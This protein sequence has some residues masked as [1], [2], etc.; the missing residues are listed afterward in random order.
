LKNTDL[1]AHFQIYF[2]ITSIFKSLK[3]CTIFD[4]SPLHQFSKFNNFLWVCWFLGK[5][6][7]NFV[8]PAWKLFIYDFKME[9]K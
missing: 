3:W 5:N 8:T 7:F 6:L 9:N 2:L 1:E 4:S